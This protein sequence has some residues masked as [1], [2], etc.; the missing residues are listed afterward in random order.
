VVVLGG[1]SHDAWAGVILRNKLDAADGD[2]YRVDNTTDADAGAVAAVEFDGPSVTP[3]GA[4][5][6]SFPWCPA[7][8]RCS[9]T[10][11]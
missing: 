8:G 3:P 9:L 10:Q 11:D 1:D 6:H 7:V 4:F 5:E 2:A